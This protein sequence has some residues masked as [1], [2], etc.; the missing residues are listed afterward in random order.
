MT[1]PMLINDLPLELAAP[2]AGLCYTM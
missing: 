1:D 2:C